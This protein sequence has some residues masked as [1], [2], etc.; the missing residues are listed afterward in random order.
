MQ[1]LKIKQSTSMMS[2]PGSKATLSK[3]GI[4]KATTVL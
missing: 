3:K 4:S 1:K 2:K